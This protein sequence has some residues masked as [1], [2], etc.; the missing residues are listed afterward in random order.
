VIAETM[1]GNGDRA[2]QY[3]S[4]V[5]PAARNDIIE[6]YECEPYAYAQ[7]ILGDEHPQFG[8]ARN[9][10]LSGTASWSYLAATQ[11]ILGIRP[12][13]TGLRI[14]PCIPPAWKGFSVERRFRGQKMHIEVH[15]PKKICKGVLKM[16]IDG[17][18]TKGDIIPTDLPGNEHHVEVW[19]GI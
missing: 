3:Y 13:F 18:T 8:L 15:N 2:Y 16:S 1:L 9:S 19:L 7:N 11:W 6:V 14:D 17:K 5:N 4:Q 12:E 10:W